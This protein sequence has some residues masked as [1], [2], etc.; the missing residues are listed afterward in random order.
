MAYND[1][2]CFLDTSC[3]ALASQSPY[4]TILLSS[5]DGVV[6][7]TESS[8]APLLW[9]IN[10]RTAFS[11]ILPAFHSSSIDFVAFFFLQDSFIYFCLRLIANILQYTHSSE[12]NH[13]PFLDDRSQIRPRIPILCLSPIRA[14]APSSST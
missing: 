1:N 10:L 12:N 4:C 3:L 5:L 7:R 14:F 9:S 2:S 11:E 8:L 6:E 13:L